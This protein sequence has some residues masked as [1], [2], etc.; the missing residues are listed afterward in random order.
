MKNGL[1]L[2]YQFFIVHFSTQNTATGSGILD[3]QIVVAGI[4]TSG[5]HAGNTGGGTTPTATV[6]TLCNQG[7]SVWVQATFTG[8]ER[9]GFINLNWSSAFSGT[10]L[11]LL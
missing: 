6:I 1:I 7:D 2:V 4:Q 10:L 8:G 5:I 9:W 3:L 11:A